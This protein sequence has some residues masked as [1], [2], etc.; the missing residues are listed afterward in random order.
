MTA[1]HQPARKMHMMREIF[2]VTEINDKDLFRHVSSRKIHC[3]T[4]VTMETVEGA[5]LLWAPDPLV[6]KEKNVNIMR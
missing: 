1:C 2:S 6:G 3:T 4:L 5:K